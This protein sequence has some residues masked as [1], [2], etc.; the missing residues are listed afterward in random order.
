MISEAHLEQAKQVLEPMMS[1]DIEVSFV[2]ESR[3]SWCVARSAKKGWPVGVSQGNS[4]EEAAQRLLE[5]YKL[6][7]MPEKPNKVF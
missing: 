4:P 5:R 7:Q 1:E 2:A 3:F 6:R